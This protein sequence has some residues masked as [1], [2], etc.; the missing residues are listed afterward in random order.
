MSPYWPGSKWGF[1][2]IDPDRIQGFSYET[3]TA[4]YYQDRAGGLL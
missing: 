2:A 3:D 4:L 1:L